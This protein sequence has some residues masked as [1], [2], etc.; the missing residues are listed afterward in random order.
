MNIFMILLFV[1]I[2]TLLGVFC[3]MLYL[4]YYYGWR[5][6]KSVILA[7]LLLMSMPPVV[8]YGTRT[9]GKKIC[10][11]KKIR[12]IRAIYVYANILRICIIVLPV[13][14]NDALNEIP[15]SFKK[16]KQ[17]KKLSLKELYIALGSSVSTTAETYGMTA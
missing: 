5:G 3:G 15:P 12:G 6:F 7:F 10:A 13:S 16:K 8:V 14:L 4:L 9:L 17:R 2:A 1:A 11:E